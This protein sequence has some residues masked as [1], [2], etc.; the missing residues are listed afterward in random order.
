MV[1]IKM[2]E[3][4]EGYLSSLTLSTIAYGLDKKATNVGERNA[5]IFDLGGGT[6]DVTS[7]WKDYAKVPRTEKL[8]KVMLYVNM[9]VNGV[10]LKAFVDSGAQSTIISKS[11]VERCGGSDTLNLCSSM[12][13]ETA[14]LWDRLRLP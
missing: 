10:P 6:F 1:L 14:A 13:R 9:E 11:C 7:V 4:P 2:H 3:I 5:F 12:N 8:G